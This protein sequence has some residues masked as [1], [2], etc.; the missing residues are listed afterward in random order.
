MGKF[1]GMTKR[2]K[3]QLV[4]DLLEDIE[5][6]NKNSMKTLLKE[7]VRYLS[8]RDV[9]TAAYTLHHELDQLELEI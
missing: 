1:K 8:E 3:I 2:E 6:G 5:D 9:D 7:T 4:T